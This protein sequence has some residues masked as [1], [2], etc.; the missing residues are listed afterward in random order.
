MNLRACLTSL[1]L[2]IASGC[3]SGEGGDGSP[4]VPVPCAGSYDDA[5]FGVN[6]TPPPALTG[7]ESAD[8]DGA[9]RIVVWQPTILTPEP[10][11]VALTY[12]IA[13]LDVDVNTAAQSALD[14]QRNTLDADPNQTILTDQSVA[15][16]SG[17]DGSVLTA[18]SN[19]GGTATLF[20]T[21][22]G[23]DRFATV[24]MV[25]P[26]DAIETMLV[27]ALSLCVE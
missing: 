10:I 7:P 5:T 16:D 19:D 25:G 17:N 21:A 8:S 14:A 22:A 9:L 20:V 27:Y 26:N 13:P 24:A 15:L 18:I 3:G 4:L 1:L 6:F 2:S 23:A 12:P 11:A